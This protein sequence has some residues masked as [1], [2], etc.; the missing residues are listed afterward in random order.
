MNCIWT[1]IGA[2]NDETLRLEGVSA[3]VNRVKLEMESH[4]SIHF[5]CHATQD[6]ENPL[7]SGFYLQDGRLELVDIMKL[8][9]A[10]R[11]LAFL[12]A[13]QTSTGTE[14]LSEEAVHLA[15]GM[16]A[17]GYRSVV[18]TMWSIKDRHGPVVAEGFYKYLMEKEM[19]SGESRPDSSNAAH[20]LHH[21]IQ[22]I[23]EI[24]GDSEQSL[25]T[26]IPY[27]HFGY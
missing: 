11:D 10:V 9:F 6:L 22:G 15:A 14:K 1:T 2:S 7:K 21:A 25:L 19:T 13:S 8:K 3:S 23:R 24:L 27:V 17:A 12:S 4:R 5:A 26:W 20:A 18:A 16:L